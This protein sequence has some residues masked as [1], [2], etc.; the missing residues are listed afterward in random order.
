[1]GED[2]EVPPPVPEAGW[3]DVPEEPVL[4]PVPVAV[5]VLV[6]VSVPDDDVVVVPRCCGTAGVA[7]AAEAA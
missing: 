3:V 7:G 1:V 5:P 4:V 2:A 6:P